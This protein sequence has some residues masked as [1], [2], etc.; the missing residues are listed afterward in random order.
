VDGWI[1][2]S[3]TL[4]IC[5]PPTMALPGSSYLFS[6]IVSLLF[7]LRLIRFRSFAFGLPLCR[8]K[9]RPS[10]TASLSLAKALRCAEGNSVPGHTSQVLPISAGSWACY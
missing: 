8:F 9:A 6:S 2:P 1:L 4:P 5:L 10:R 3:S 7:L